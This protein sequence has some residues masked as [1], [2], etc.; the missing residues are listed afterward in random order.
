MVNHNKTTEFLANLVLLKNQARPLLYTCLDAIHNKINQ[1]KKILTIQMNK[2][3]QANLVLLL[4]S[5][6]FQVHL[7]NL[8][9]LEK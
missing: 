5:T 8:A 4:M 6:I 2:T 9:S 1:A 7:A 3:S